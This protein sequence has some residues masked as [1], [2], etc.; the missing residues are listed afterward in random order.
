MLSIIITNYK[1]PEL[2]R[3]CVESLKETIR[4]TPYEIIAVDSESDEKS[5]REALSGWSDVKLIAF[6]N[7][8]GYAKAVNAGLKEARGDYFLILNADMKAVPEAVDDMMDFMKSEAIRQNIGMIGPRLYGFDD[9][10]QQT[11][12]RFYAPFT[13]LLRRTFLGG[14]PRFKNHLDRFLMKDKN[15][16]TTDSPQP[17][18]WLMGTALL[19]AKKAVEK[20]GVMDERF[21][22]YFEDTDWARRFWEN[23]FKVFYFPKAIMYHMHS[24]ASK[25]HGAID[26]IF[27]K[28]T[29]NHIKSALLYFIKY[30][31]KTK[32]YA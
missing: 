8:V 9:K 6:R 5:A 28:M 24:R 1:K 2:L 29:R 25:K 21:F 13:I 26:V 20:T 11:T 22:M 4:R 3:G 17:V 18:D 7:N 27:N 15:M 32:H 14:L 23:G 19:V 30:R 12:F 31:F 16:D 10:I